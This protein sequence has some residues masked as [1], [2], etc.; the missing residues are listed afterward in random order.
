[1]RSQGQEQWNVEMWEEDF[2]G[3]CIWT[4]DHLCG[5]DHLGKQNGEANIVF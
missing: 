1:M 4:G 2:G 5:G 3:G